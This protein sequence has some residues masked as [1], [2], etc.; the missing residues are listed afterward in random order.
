MAT[1]ELQVEG[2]TGLTISSSDTN[3]T[4]AQ[5]TEFLKDGVIDVTNRIVRI[6]PQDRDHF[7]RKTASDSQGVE[8]GRADIISVAREANVDGSTDGSPS[9]R[10]CRK[11]PVY[12]QSRVVDT[13]SLHFAS[14]YNPVYT[15]DDTGVVNVYPIPSSNNG[16]EVYYINN[17]PVNGSGV[18]LAFSHDDIKY[19]P[20]SKIYLVVLY[21]SIKSLEQKMGDYAHSEEDIELVKAMTS[22]ISALKVQYESAFEAMVPPQQRKQ[23]VQ[24][25]RR[26]G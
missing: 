2:T 21:A 15:L 6:R 3:P 18:S 20:S 19:F 11:I 5:L 7:T 17:T 8:F 10:N 26:R 12:L 23:A 9:W 4:Q 24:Q 22:N 16:I 14:I 1:F 25:D 13:D